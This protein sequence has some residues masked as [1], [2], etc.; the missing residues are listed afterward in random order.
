MTM[1]DDDRLA[2]LLAR[3]G[4]AFEVPASGA[5]EILARAAGPRPGGGR[6]RGDTRYR[7]GVARRHGRRRG[8]AAT[9]AAT[10]RRRSAAGGCGALAA[11]ADRHRVLAAAACIVVAL[12]VA[13][14]VGAL[15]RTTSARTPHLG[16]AADDPCRTAAG[17]RRRP[18]PSEALRRRV[19]L[20]PQQRRA[21]RCQRRQRGRQGCDGGA[22]ADRGHH[23]H[24][25]AVPAPTPS[26]SPAK[27]EQ[28]GTLGLSV[29]RGTHLAGP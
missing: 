23:A 29:G 14:T 22:A 3:A 20:Q 1:L 5:A 7:R 9:R 16:T 17:E 21:V 12:I 18:S 24:D 26:A 10:R 28:T 13:G 2:S 25:D 11:L 15:V 6:R 8:D 19:A 4:D 27:I